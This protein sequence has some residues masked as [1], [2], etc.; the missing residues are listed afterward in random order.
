MATR[1]RT[2]HPLGSDLPEQ[3][4]LL[5]AS[6]VPLQFRLDERTR[7]RGLQ[8]IAQIRRMLE[9]HASARQDVQPSHAAR[10]AA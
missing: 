8:Q 1:T 9:Q 5:P 3:L 7:R 4:A 2:P 6:E 10:R